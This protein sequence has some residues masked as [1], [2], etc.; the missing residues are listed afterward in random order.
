MLD[1][2]LTWTI[3]A[4]KLYAQNDTMGLDSLIVGFTLILLLST[5]TRSQIK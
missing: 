1:K 4:L 5:Q 2:I 3:T